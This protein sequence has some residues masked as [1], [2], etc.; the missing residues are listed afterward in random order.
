MAASFVG[1]VNLLGL[2][3]VGVVAAGPALVGPNANNGFA[4]HLKWQPFLTF[5]HHGCRSSVS[6]MDLVAISS[7]LAPWRRLVMLVCPIGLFLSSC[8]N[9][10]SL[11]S[12]MKREHT[13]I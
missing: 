8:V 5:D 6:D 9:A 12:L 11:Q 10:G 3:V 7:I 4:Q 2:L 1:L 13:V